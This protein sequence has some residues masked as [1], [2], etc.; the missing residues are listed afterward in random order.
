MKERSVFEDSEGKGCRSAE[1]KKDMKTLLP[2]DTGSQRRWV[3]RRN[4]A[5]G[6]RGVAAE[7]EGKRVGI[8]GAVGRRG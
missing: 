1:E 7:S 5:Y 8:S 6:G 4:G 2:S 3:E